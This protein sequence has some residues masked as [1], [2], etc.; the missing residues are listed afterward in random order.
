MVGCLGQLKLT[1]CTVRSTGISEYTACLLTFK[2]HP[3]CLTPR[4]S[5]SRVHFFV[6]SESC[7]EEGRSKEGMCRCQMICGDARCRA[8]VD[9]RQWP[10]LDKH[11]CR[12]FPSQWFLDDVRHIYHC[13]LRRC[14]RCDFDDVELSARV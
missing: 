4:G 5:L 14:Y 1:W 11:C 2:D 10:N 9:F 8:R 6:S 13:W 12:L 7:L 3:V